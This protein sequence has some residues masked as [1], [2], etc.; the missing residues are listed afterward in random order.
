MQPRHSGFITCFSGAGPWE[1]LPSSVTEVG[2]E[3]R[4]GAPI[5]SH[6]DKQSP[7]GAQ[8]SRLRKE[9][10]QQWA[11]HSSLGKHMICVRIWCKMCKKKWLNWSCDGPVISTSLRLVSP[12]IRLLSVCGWVCLH[13]YIC[14]LFSRL[15]LHAQLDAMIQCSAP[16][17][18]Q[19]RCTAEGRWASAETALSLSLVLSLS[20]SISPSFPPYLSLPLQLALL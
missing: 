8:L 20:L 14:G 12:A 4:A 11:R 17:G 9:R 7:G 6:P 19:H 13:V 15:H 18:P 3:E 5:L 1:D 16:R 10:A 2:V